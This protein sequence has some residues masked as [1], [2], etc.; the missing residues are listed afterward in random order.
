MFNGCNLCKRHVHSHSLYLV[1]SICAKRTH[2]KCLPKIG[3]NDELYTR[4]NT[5]LWYC[6]V[7]VESIFPFNHLHD[8]DEFVEALN[9]FDSHNAA[10]P[11]VSDRLLNVFDYNDANENNPML[12]IDPDN[13]FYNQCAKQCDYFSI[14]DFRKKCEN[15][16]SN[17]RSLSLLHANIRS[18]RQ[19]FQS[20]ETYMQSLSFN[21]DVIGLSETWLSDDDVN[22]FNPISYNV[23]SACRS[24]KLGGGVSLLLNKSLRYSRRNDLSVMTSSIECLFV[25]IH[26][27][28]NLHNRKSGKAL[29]GVVYRPPN[30]SIDD[31]NEELSGILHSIKKESTLCY[32]MGDININLLNI[33]THPRTAQFLELMYSYSYTPLITKPTRVTHN[34]ATLIDNIFTNEQFNESSIQGILC[35]DVSDHFPVF[36]IDM[37]HSFSHTKNVFRKRCLSFSKRAKFKIDLMNSKWSGVLDSNCA[38]ESFSTFHKIF[39]DTYDSCFP[40]IISK[41]VYKNNL[42][43]LTTGL[44]SSIKVKN[45][46]YLQSIKYPTFSNVQLYKNYKRTL[47]KLLKA[48]EKQY[49]DEQLITNKNNLRKSWKLIKSAINKKKQI[50]TPSQFNINGS[51][52]DDRL[53]IA[54]SFNNFFLNIGKSLGN[55][56]KSSPVT[57]THYMKSPNMHSIFLGSTNEVEVTNI[58]FNLKNTSSGWDD[59]SSSVIKDAIQHYVKPLTHTINLSLDQGI[60]P[61]ELKI[62][63]VVPIHKNGELSEINNYRPISILPLFSKIYERL[64]YK[65]LIDFLNKYDILCKKQFGFRANYSPNTALAYLIDK[66][67]SAYD[68]KNIVLG[69]FIDLKKAFDTVNHEILKAKLEF[70]GIRGNALK[71]LVSYLDDRHQYVCYDGLNSS[72][73][74]ISCGVP[75][76]SI[77]GPLLF[78]V[79]VNDLCNVSSVVETLLY[80]DDTSLYISGSNISEMIQIMNVELEKNSSVVGNKQ[81]NFK[82]TEN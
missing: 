42:K 67:V 73:G 62:A 75:Q 80:A 3:K 65:R 26:R 71:W 19:N 68:K 79:Y 39:K 13:N 5:S 81:I 77:L 69:V 78:L 9:E 24:Q 17:Q 55:K 72:M 28:D 76:G 53:T 29:V 38:Q 6:T 47:S 16:E 50:Q 11:H 43:W 34:T 82:C 23:E 36:L 1:C 57:C 32:L 58:I 66:I 52:T 37:K 40:V 15:I 59:I 8:D 2:L 14:E 60:V 45:K 51:L 30:T 64:M 25:E 46:L 7:C 35:T 48:R 12:D 70:Y 44:K 49:Y 74:K 61:R 63:K 18:V 33:E 10:N 4:R 20:L 21:F 22:S 41:S 27:Y 54:N 56:I 31:F